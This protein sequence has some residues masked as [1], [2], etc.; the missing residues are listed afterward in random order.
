M[1]DST[2]IY[3]FFFHTTIDLLVIVTLQYVYIF[4]KCLKSLVCYRKNQGPGRHSEKNQIWDR[5]VE[6]PLTRGPQSVFSTMTALV[7]LLCTYLLKVTY[8]VEF[9]NNQF[10][11]SLPLS[12]SKFIKSCLFNVHDGVT[13]P[14][15]PLA[16]PVKFIF[17]VLRWEKNI[18]HEVWSPL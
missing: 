15:T 8:F 12:L 4:L 16:E 7:F 13:T 18:S 14:S 17:I 9:V 3:H 1:Y 5:Y 2:L 11:C 6:K 10:V